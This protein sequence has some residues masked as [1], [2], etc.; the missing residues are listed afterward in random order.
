M[1]C[2]TMGRYFTLFN[3]TL[4]NGY[5]GKFYG[6]DVSAQFFLK[7]ASCK[8]ICLTIPFVL[9]ITLKEIS[10]LYLGYTCVDK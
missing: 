4:K 10:H 9:V 2:A 7:K 5:G 6:M 8:T 1:G 3:S